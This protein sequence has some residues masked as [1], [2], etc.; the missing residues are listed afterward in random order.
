MQRTCSCSEDDRLLSRL[1]P[2][3]LVALV[4]GRALAQ[5]P[6][7]EP[8]AAATVLP[9]DIPGVL[10]IK[11]TSAWSEFNRFHSFPEQIAG[12]GGLPFFPPLGD[13]ESTIQPWIGE[14][15]LTSTLA[16]GNLYLATIADR[17][18]TLIPVTDPQGLEA[19]I[20][21]LESDRGAPE[22]RDYQGVTVLVWEPE[23]IVRPEAEPEAKQLPPQ[24]LPLVALGKS[25]DRTLRY[26]LVRQWLAQ[27]NEPVPL[28]EPPPTQPQT[29]PGIAIALLPGYV[30]AAS[31]PVPLEQLIDEFD[32]EAS[33][34]ENPEFQKLL[35]HPQYDEA[36]A[37]VYGDFSA[38]ADA[39]ANPP[40]S[41]ENAPPSPE[42]A[43][44]EALENVAA[45]YTT[46]YSVAWFA[47]TGMQV[48][49]RTFYAPGAR[50]QLDWPTAATYSVLDRQ[51]ADTFLTVASLD[52]S[53]QWQRVLTYYENDPTT[54]EI[55]A[56]LRN[57]SRTALNLDFDREVIGWM[58]GEYSFF[59]FPT[60]D[61][62]FP[63]LDPNIR[64]GLGM[65]FQTRDRASGDRF[66]QALNDWI[67]VESGGIVNVVETRVDG[68][69]ATS[70]EFYG[71]DE[72][73]SSQVAFAWT[74]DNTLMITTGTAPLGELLSPAAP[75]GQSELF[76]SAIAPLPKPNVGYF[77][78]NIES[79]IPFLLEIFPPMDPLEVQQFREFSEIFRGISSTATVEPTFEQSDAFLLMSPERSAP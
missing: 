24:Q 21:L 6:T 23:E 39:F 3:A 30:A 54:N 28:P 25:L 71:P 58:N 4:P 75:L 35:A 61:G 33:L 26:P 69:P 47:P 49:G 11:T 42:A 62:F 14:W 57:W 52:L 41:S 38:I 37:T 32:P 67:A 50:A 48:Q 22:E 9:A 66:L 29:R 44:V 7:P 74:N 65:A 76:Q 56:A 72:K 31:N 19:Y 10:A 51:P 15:A 79:L 13:F 70:W 40:P 59:I 63:R 12:P 16:D 5:N 68:R 64:V 73:V 17:A 46:T 34:A 1:L 53:T 20:D 2:L 78:L 45:E 27:A 18:F 8:P 60:D 43:L 55:L 36:V 77:F